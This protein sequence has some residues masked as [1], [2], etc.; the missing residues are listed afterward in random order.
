LSNHFLYR[1]FS[2]DGTLLYIGVTSCPVDRLQNHKYESHWAADI[3]R[4]EM[5]RF[6][7]TEEAATAERQAISAEKPLHNVT[8][9]PIDQTNDLCRK[10]KNWMDLNNWR[11]VDA[12]KHLHVKAR[13]VQRWLK[14]DRK[15]PNWVSTVI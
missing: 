10:L 4:I 7:S 11:P 13:T 9:V 12:A 1:H 14:G 3:D 15:V 8:Y 6:G 2:K 5:M